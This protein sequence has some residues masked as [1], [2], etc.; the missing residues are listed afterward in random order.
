MATL[1]D[2][3]DY[4]KFADNARMGSLIKD[5]ESR[6]GMTG[7]DS[8]DEAASQEGN[9]SFR[10]SLSSSELNYINAAGIPDIWQANA[11]PDPDK[12]DRP[13]NRP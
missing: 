5:T 3:L 12:K 13:W 1:R 9:S 8:E 6:Y 11:A 10:R 7:D 4:Q 2:I